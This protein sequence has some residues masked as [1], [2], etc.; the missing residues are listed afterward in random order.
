[1]KLKLSL[2]QAADARQR[3][4]RTRSVIPQNAKLAA[5]PIP[6]K[7]V[8]PAATEYTPAPSVS[9][10][11]TMVMLNKAFLSHSGKVGWPCRSKAAP[12]VKVAPNQEPLPNCD[13]TPCTAKHKFRLDPVG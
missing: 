4:A 12:N 6:Q 1:M 5:I 11:A 10:P 7:L 3:K 8:W 2:A 13:Q 9:A